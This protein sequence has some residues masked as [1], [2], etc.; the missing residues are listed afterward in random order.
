MF[1]FDFDVVGA[2]WL[3]IDVESSA[4]S[5]AYLQA[6]LNNKIFMIEENNFYFGFPSGLQVFDYIVD[7]QVVETIEFNIIEHEISYYNYMPPEDYQLGDV[8]NDGSISILDIIIIVNGIMGEELEYL[9]FLSAD[10]NEDGILNVL[11]V[12]S[13]VNIILNN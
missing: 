10:L 2:G 1:V 9:E 7:G 3:S 8:N 4:N 6:H 5:N 12:I 11:D 13:I